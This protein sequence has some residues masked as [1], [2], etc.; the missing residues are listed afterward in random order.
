M[1]YGQR[2]VSSPCSPLTSFHPDSF[3]QHHKR[4]RLSELLVG[5][6][7]LR[8]ILPGLAEK[9]RC[10]LVNSHVV[11]LVLHPSSCLTQLA[12]SCLLCVVPHRLRS[13][14]L[15]TKGMFQS[16]KHEWKLTRPLHA[17]TTRQFNRLAQMSN[18]PCLTGVTGFSM[19]RLASKF[20]RS[21]AHTSTKTLFAF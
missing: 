11:S 6:E 9:A 18:A 4:I 8:G 1:N 16:P 15:Q 21:G 10:L 17:F 12:K 14:V 5:S 2:S 3:G 13:T 20:G 19:S 7:G